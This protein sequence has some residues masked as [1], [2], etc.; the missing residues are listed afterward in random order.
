MKLSQKIL[1]G[2]FLLTGLQLVL[3]SCVGPGYVETGVYYG[4]PYRD[5]WF[6]DGPWMDGHRGYYG[7][8]GGRADVYISPPRINLPSPPGIHI[9]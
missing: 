4:G 3:T 1:L 2:S 8:G 5:P 9:R 7:G 6:H